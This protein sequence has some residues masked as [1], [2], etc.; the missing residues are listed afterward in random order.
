M[1]EFIAYL[2][3]TGADGAPPPRH[4]IAAL[5]LAPAAAFAAHQARL[6]A[7]LAGPDGGPDAPAD[8]GLRWDRLDW[9]T[10]ADIRCH[11]VVV[12]RR[13][14]EADAPG[15]RGRTVGQVVHGAVCEAIAVA[16]R[17]TEVRTDA[18][19]VAALSAGFARHAVEGRGADLFRPAPAV[20]AAEPGAAPMRL[21]VLLARRVAQCLRDGTDGPELRA[22]LRAG[23]LTLEEWPPAQDRDPPARSPLEDAADAAVRR[24][25]VDAAWRFIAGMPVPRDEDGRVQRIVLTHLLFTA[26]HGDGGYVSS[27]E[28]LRL[29]AARGY[30]NLQEHYLQSAIVAGLRDSGVPVTSSSRG[31][32][33]PQARQDLLDF[34]NLV[35]GQVIPLLERLAR[36][37]QALGAAAGGA[38]WDLG[39][40][41]HAKL[42]RVMDALEDRAGPVGPPGGSTPGR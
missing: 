36:V 34:V 29:L 2:H 33:I 6:A 17:D 24:A 39:D 30:D 12:D 9:L 15:L 42:R 21:A 41:R 40:A 18:P 14:T 20:R 3:E 32:K 19:G 11:A 8:G 26:L 25:A 23:W 28:L 22:P 27:A 16:G 4:R 1:A 31:Y 38:A 5:A 10:D 13:E 37:R 7:A 35:D